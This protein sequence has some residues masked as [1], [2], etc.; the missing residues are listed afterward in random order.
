MSYDAASGR[1]DTEAT[2]RGGRLVL[3]TSPGLF[4]GRKYRAYTEFVAAKVLR[5]VATKPFLLTDQRLSVTSGLARAAISV[6]STPGG[7]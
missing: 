4:K 6:G 5:L 2:F 3:L 1:Q 7:T